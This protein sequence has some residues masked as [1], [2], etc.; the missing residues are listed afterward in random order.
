MYCSIVYHDYSNLVEIFSACLY[1][2]LGGR[3]QFIVLLSIYPVS[4][5]LNLMRL[6]GLLKLNAGD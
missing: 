3:V 2:I 5:Y 6:V 4:H 1:V